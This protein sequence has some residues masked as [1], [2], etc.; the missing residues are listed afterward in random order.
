LAEKANE[1]EESFPADATT[2]KMSGLASIQPAAKL[3]Y[4]MSAHL[5]P[6]GLIPSPTSSV[7]LFF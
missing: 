2:M 1:E 3:A 7:I 6:Q 5:F 4:P